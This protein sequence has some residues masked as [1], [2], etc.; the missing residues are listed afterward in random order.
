MPGVR[1]EL[2]PGMTLRLD[3]V[4]RPAA[5]Y[6]CRHWH[7]SRSVPAGRLNILGVWEAGQFK[8][9]V[10]FSKGATPKIGSPYGLTQT[11]V[12]ELTRVALRDH[13][14]PVSRIIAVAL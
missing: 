4:A 2:R 7:Y 6:A 13:D 14:A 1:R 9:V 5:E 10:I 11:E 12:C 3:W 8:G